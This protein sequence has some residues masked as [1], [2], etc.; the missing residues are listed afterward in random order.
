MAS[1]RFFSRLRN[2]CALMITTPSWL[3]RRSP[4]AASRARTASGS[5]EAAMSKRRCTAFDTLLTFWPPAPW[6]RMA[7]SS[8]S[9]GA[10]TMR[11]DTQRTSSRLASQAA[12]LSKPMRFATVAAMFDRP[13]PS[14]AFS[15]SLPPLTL[16]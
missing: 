8:T 15:P 9:S 7:V 13:A 3:M 12:C 2:F 6:A 4:S 1:A 10:M 14:T 5:D 16:S 11:G